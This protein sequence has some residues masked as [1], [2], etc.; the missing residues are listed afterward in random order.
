MDRATV[1]FKDHRR[2]V[3]RGVHTKTATSETYS[4]VPDGYELADITVT[5]DLAA[6]A[7][8]M[9]VKAMKNTSGRSKCAHGAVVV[10]ATNKRRVQL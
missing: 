7:R 5:V 1:T 4:T 2:E 8:Q 10:T 3:G 9:A 6:L